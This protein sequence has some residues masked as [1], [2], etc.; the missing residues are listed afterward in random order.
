LYMYHFSNTT[1]NDVITYGFQCD[2]IKG[3][4]IISNKRT[5]LYNT[6]ARTILM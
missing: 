1:I 3:I 2:V 6:S 5:N 4:F